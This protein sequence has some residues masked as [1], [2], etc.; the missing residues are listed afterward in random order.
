MVGK[1]LNANMAARS[2]AQKRVKESRLIFSTCA[3]A[4]LGLLRTEKFEVVL[5]DEASQQTEPETLIPLVKGCRRAVFVGDHVQLRATVQ[6]TA[7]VVGYDVSL[8]ERHY[9]MP[10]QQGVA[11]VML[12]MQYRM[13]ADVCA[14]SS[15]EFYRGELQTA[16]ADT[17][18]PLIP[19][20]FPWPPS[21]R[22][23]F[24]Q[25]PTTEDIGH[26]SKANRGQAMLCRRVCEFLC[27]AVATDGT[28][29]SP[30]AYTPSQIAVLTP[31][32]RQKELLKSILPAYDVSSIDGYQG[33]EANIVIFVTVRSNVHY[34]LGFLTDLRRLNVAMTRARTAVIVIG[35]RATL[36]GVT[37][38]ETADESKKCWTRLLQQ[39]VE[40][41]LPIDTM[42][43]PKVDQDDDLSQ[44]KRKER[45]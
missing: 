1:D 44:K 36:T 30:R 11:K 26:Q 18:R 21:G 25:C 29:E 38:G 34:E 42:D 31:Y 10:P 14:F 43:G 15:S 13:H 28:A 8:F 17:S 23:V 3:G 5:V 41:D 19:S 9:D 6:K 24:I 33:R 20:K 35:D 39:C 27:T 40:I 37:P 45:R 7:V 2:K 32:T 4:G 16:V 12:N 22:K